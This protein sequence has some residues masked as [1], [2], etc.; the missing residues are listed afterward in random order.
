MK[1]FKYILAKQILLVRLSKGFNFVFRL[2]PFPILNPK[3]LS[4]SF[5]RA[6]VP[7]KAVFLQVKLSKKACDAIH[8]ECI[9]TF[10]KWITLFFPG[11]HMSGKRQGDVKAK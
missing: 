1:Y 7:L 10:S 8:Q 9:S 4:Y 3:K 2:I 6:R 11:Q 5:L